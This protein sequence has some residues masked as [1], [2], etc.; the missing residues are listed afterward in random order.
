FRSMFKTVVP[1]GYG[2]CV[3]RNDGD[4]IFH[5]DEKRSLNEN[6]VEECSHDENLQSLL[7]TRLPGFT[8]SRYSGSSQ[9]FYISPVPNMPYS[10]VTYRDLRTI[11]AEDLDVIS[12][13]SILC[14]MN[15]AVILLAIIIIQA[16]GYRRSLL[17]SQSILFRWLR[18]NR[19]LK[20][21]Y[22]AVSIFY[23]CSMILQA[24]FFLFYD[25][26]DRLCLVGISFSYSYILTAYAYIQFTVLN[27]SDKGKKQ[28]NKGP[29]YMLS[30]VYVFTSVLFLITLHSG[31][32]MYVCSQLTLLV[33]GW[34][35]AR[36]EFL[37]NAIMNQKDFR[38][39]YVFSLF[40][41]MAATSITPLINFYLLSFKE[42]RLL[43]LKRNQ[44]EFV[45]QLMQQP[46]DTLAHFPTAIRNSYQA[47]FY[48]ESFSDS[49]VWQHKTFPAPDTEINGFE[50]L[51]KRIK[52]SF[53]VHSREM[54]TLIKKK[55][56][57]NNEFNWIYKPLSGQLQLLYKVSKTQTYIDSPGIMVYSTLKS[58]VENTGLAIKDDWL[59][60]L[61]LIGSLL[62]FLWGFYF[63]LNRLI[64]RIFFKGYDNA[65]YLTESDL[66]LIPSLPSNENI[67]VN[68]AI[69]SGKST[70]LKSYFTEK[71]IDVH[72]ID[73]VTLSSDGADIMAELNDKAENNKKV[74]LIRHFEL[75]MKDLVMTE[76]KLRLFESLLF[77]KK[78]IFVLSSRSFDSMVTRNGKTG[79]EAIDFTDRWSN[80]M[81]QFYNL[82]HKWKKPEQEDELRK[83]TEAVMIETTTQNFN[84]HVFETHW[85]VERVKRIG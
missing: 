61:V 56:T 21:T 46:A 32:W 11:W 51:Y 26:K 50:T 22:R 2:F 59:S 1:E 12:A 83:E 49:I 66:S 4:V 24:L 5:L 72:E 82:Y 3:V 39:W 14:L 44:I 65:F 69:N 54:E 84:A 53:S 43:S 80:V 16:T 23:G 38:W 58:E 28:L 37:S 8:S 62:L 73:M 79:T 42:E 70:K 67:F 41:F 29:I 74:V 81:N 71:K 18:P 17:Q 85:I 33:I 48:F 10:I 34:L 57:S 64:Q 20:K 31:H 60:F 36:S 30:A 63:L 13:C 77:L 47:P 52:P 7:R 35:F 40:T 55:D 76:K 75:F 27:E 68:G 25:Q 78:Q 19:E 45:R 6:L 15:L 9:Q